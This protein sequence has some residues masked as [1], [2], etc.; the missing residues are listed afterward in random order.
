MLC[1]ACEASWRA[2]AASS[3]STTS[4]EGACEG[5]SHHKGSGGILAPWELG[6]LEAP[7]SVWR[8]L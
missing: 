2:P 1:S 6:M 7:W 8:A 3:P 5:P 4:L